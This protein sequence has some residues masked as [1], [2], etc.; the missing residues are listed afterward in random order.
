MGPSPQGTCAAVAMSGSNQLR[1]V[2]CGRST[3]MSCKRVGELLS[4]SLDAELSPWQRLALAVHLG[5]CRWCRLFRR[6]SGWWKKPAVGGGGRTKPLVVPPRFRLS[7]GRHAS[8]SRTPFGRLIPRVNFRKSC[9]VLPGRATEYEG[10]EQRRPLIRLNTE[11]QRSTWI[12]AGYAAEAV[13]I[14][15]AWNVG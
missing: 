15:A 13:A 7:A 1:P 4:Q 10:R 12:V 2:G 3:M 8:E 11:G 9:Q 6:S 5:G 14:L